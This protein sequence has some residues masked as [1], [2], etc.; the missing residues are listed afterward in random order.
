MIVAWDNC[1]DVQ[2]EFLGINVTGS[3]SDGLFP[4]ARFRVSDTAGLVASCSVS[5]IPLDIIV[6]GLNWRVPSADY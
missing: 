3:V 5:V 1:D 6:S 2:A 4:V